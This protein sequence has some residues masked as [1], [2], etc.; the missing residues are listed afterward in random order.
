MELNATLRTVLGKKTRALRGTGLIPAEVFGHG[1]SNRHISVPA[2]EFARVYR[3]AGEHT[4]VTLSL[5]G[6]EKVSTVISDI[7]RDGITGAVLSIDFHE[8]RMDEKIQAKI[9]IHFT[10]EA[11]AKKLG[12]P[13]LMTLEEIEVEAL[14]A[15]LPHSFEVDISALETPGQSISIEDLKIPADVKVLVP[16][17]T[18]IA[19]VGEKT[20]EEV[21]VPVPTAETATTEGAAAGSEPTGDTQAKPASEKPAK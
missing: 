8:I 7:S 16:P 5:G 2:K 18:V 21:V 20:K 13:V 11:A 10:G 15:K 9:P 4:I 19:T 6:T 14:P 1:V 12:F 17:E 3:E